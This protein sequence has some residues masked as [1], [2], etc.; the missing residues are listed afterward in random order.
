MGGNEVFNIGDLLIV[1]SVHRKS[2]N[3]AESEPGFGKGIG[4]P[5]GKWGGKE[6]G[7]VRGHVCVEMG[8]KVC[9][10]TPWSQEV[11]VEVTGPERKG[12]SGALVRILSW[13]Q[14]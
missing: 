14:N 8:R 2:A 10:M 5:K 1:P 6:T 13:E 3:I 11:R 4:S 12:F 9:H 7:W